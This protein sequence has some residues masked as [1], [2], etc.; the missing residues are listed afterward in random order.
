MTGIEAIVDGVDARVCHPRDATVADDRFF[1]PTRPPSRRA[2]SSTRPGGEDRARAPARPRTV[3]GTSELLARVAADGASSTSTPTTGTWSRRGSSA[4]ATRCS[5]WAAATASGCS[6]TRSCSRSSRVPMAGPGEGALP[7]TTGSRPR[8]IPVSEPLLGERE[9]EYVAECLRDRLDLLGWPVHRRVRS[10]WAAYC[11]RR[12]GVAVANGTVALQP[13]SPPSV[14]PATRSSCRRFTIIS[15]ALA[16]VYAGAT[17]VLVDTDPET[18]C[19]DV[20]QVEAR[21]TSRDARD[22]AG[23]H[24]RPSR[25]TWT[26]CSSWP[27]RHGLAII[28]DAAEAH[29]AEYLSTDGGDRGG[30]AGASATL[31][32][33]SFYAN[34]LVT[35]GEGGMVLTDDDALAERLRSLAQPRLRARAALPPRR[36]GPQLPAD[37]RPGRDRR[38]PGR[39]DR[40]DRRPQA[41]DRRALRRAALR[42]LPAIRFQVERAWAR[43][44]YWMYGVVL[45][46][47]RRA[48]TPRRSRAG[49]AAAGVETRPFF[50]G[51]ARA[52]GARSSAACSRT[53]R[54]RSPTSSRAQG[55]YLPSGRR[56]HR[57]AGRPRPRG[58]R[59]GARVTRG[60]RRG[61]R[62]GLRRCSMRTRTTRRSATCSR[63]VFRGS[64][65]PVRTVLDLGCGTG[66]HAIRLAQRGYEVTGVDLSESMLAVAR[67]RAAATGADGSSSSTATSG[68]SG[69][70]ATFDAAICMFAVL[71][72]QTPT[73]MSLLRSPP[74]GS[75]ASRGPVRIRCLVRTRCRGDRSDDAGQGGTAG[76]G[77]IERHATAVLEPDRQLCTVSYRLDPSRAWGP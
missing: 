64:A 59:G 5:P 31:S 70:G 66:A 51:H 73:Q 33:F 60:V 72:Y 63:Q 23:P 57:R 15:C 27:T 36:A 20:A 76:E 69:S 45:E 67:E 28:E 8:V 34:K 68:P 56:P 39:A 3:V 55:L 21:I 65:R 74:C 71:G 13:R 7:T 53:R 58:D 10:A 6:R 48:S 25:S 11:G 14:G 41:G 30:A 44:V 16:V 4:R 61:L 38:R 19:M 54:T 32:C 1:T 52:A 2:S 49:C 22:H 18:W 46:R 26:R 40:R 37:E 17:P 42:R 35:T 29:G 43:S 50:L 47:R 9:A 62:G 75:T 24:L 12:Y 77:E